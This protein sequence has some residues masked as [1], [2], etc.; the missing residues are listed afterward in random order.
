[1]D[2]PG[3]I[4]FFSED[5]VNVPQ[6]VRLLTQTAKDLKATSVTDIQSTRSSVMLPIPIPFLFY[7]QST[8]VSGN[9]NK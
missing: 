2:N 1:M 6:T 5:S 7:M 3:T 9:A 8:N 4:S